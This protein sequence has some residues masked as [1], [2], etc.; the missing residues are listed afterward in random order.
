[1]KYYKELDN[2]GIA[3]RHQLLWYADRI[4]R[5]VHGPIKEVIFPVNHIQMLACSPKLR[6]LVAELGLTVQYATCYVTDT[7]SREINDIHIHVNQGAR[8]NIPVLN[9]TAARTVFYKVDP[10]YTY[11]R[12][13]KNSVTSWVSLDPNPVEVASLRI[14]RPTIIRANVPHSVILDQD[15]V[16]RI[17]MILVV[18]PDPVYMLN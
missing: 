5:C 7:T 3:I 10:Q 18:T 4:L 15:G 6:E 13:Q 17:S 9:S 2:N 1:M 8:L 11:H 14:E 12:I 16:R